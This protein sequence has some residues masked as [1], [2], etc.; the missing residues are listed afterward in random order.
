MSTSSPGPI[1][2]FDIMQTGLT[3]T[4]APATEPVTLAEAK[5]HVRVDSADHDAEL[6]SLITRAR[7]LCES[8]T[9]RQFITATW[10]VKFDAFPFAR[11]I[12]FP[13]PPLQSV[14]QVS[15]FDVNDNAQTYASSNYRVHTGD[16]YGVLELVNMATWP[17]TSD[18][19]DAVTITYV[20]GYGDN[21]SD[22]PEPLKQAMLLLIGHWFSNRESVVIG[23]SATVVPQTVEYLLGPYTVEA[24]TRV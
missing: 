15:Y 24:F 1:F 12:V 13:R 19:L 21:A 6:T 5:T 8:L 16:V 3:Q 22:V 17:T 7:M 11:K 20:A 14:S 23:P 18:R 2:P 10:S 4:V 9:Q